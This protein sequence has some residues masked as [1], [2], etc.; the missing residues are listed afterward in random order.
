MYIDKAKEL[1]N[2]SGIAQIIEPHGN[3]NKAPT[4]GASGQTQFLDKYRIK[5]VVS[6]ALL[7]VLCSRPG[8]T[9]NKRF[10]LFE[11]STKVYPQMGNPV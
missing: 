4:M 3:K 6:I 5:S 11:I 1:S 9:F 2:N 8:T 10:Q 7:K